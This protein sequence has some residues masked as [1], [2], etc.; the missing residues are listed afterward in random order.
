MRIAIFENIM[1]PGGHE[2]DF[3][4]ILVEELQAL[5]HEVC[6]YVPEEFQF[7]LDYHVPVHYLQG[8]VISYTGVRGIKK[9]VRSLQREI[10]RLRWYR[11]L[12]EEA[13]K[14]AFDA[15]IIPTSTYRYLRALSR[16]C[17]RQSPVP[18]AFLLHGINPQ[19]APKFLTAVKNLEAYT[20][21]RPI[22][23]TLA[24]SIFGALPQNVRLIYP[25]TFIPRDIDWRPDNKLQFKEFTKI[26]GVLRIG[27]FGQY[28]REKRLEDFLQTYQQ[29]NYHRPVELL[30]QGSTMHPEDAQDFER[31]CKKYGH[32]QGIKFLHQGLVGASWQ[33]AIASVDALLLPYSAPRYRY[34]WGGML[35]TAIGFEKPVIAS[36][37]MNPEVFSAFPIGKTFP[38]GNLQELAH[39]LEA[40]INHFDAD[41]AT[42]Q[43]A[44][45]EAAKL[46]SPTLFARRILDILQK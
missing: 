1:T 12:Y 35:F 42:Y 5:G 30:V 46:Y 16:S 29:G 14:G 8:K 19:E 18:I 32:V 20:N 3:N 17:L 24:T 6:F 22:V 26:G 7:A 25:P 28:R 11:A 43:Q 41:L 39:T 2:V 36:D 40:F 45:H 34:H 9:M 27:F 15:L 37:D 23:L 33:R 13:R 31:I 4:R 21:V 38:S 10:H 44:L